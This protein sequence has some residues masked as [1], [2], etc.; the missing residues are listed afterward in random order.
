MSAKEN[1][2][3][4][5][6]ILDGN[7]QITGNVSIPRKYSTDGEGTEWPDGI[8]ALDCDCQSCFDYWQIR[9]W[10]PNL[11]HDP[12][13][14]GCN[15]CPGIPISQIFRKHPEN[16]FI[17]D[18][19]INEY[20]DRR[21]VAALQAYVDWRDRLDAKPTNP[22][23]HAADCP[24]RECE[25]FKPEPEPVYYRSFSMAE[26]LSAVDPE[27]HWHLPLLAPAGFITLLTAGPK[28]GKTQFYYG[29]LS[30]MERNGQVLG[31]RA[32]GGLRIEIWTEEPKAGIQ[33]KMN[34]VNM[35]DIPADWRIMG[36]GDVEARDWGRQIDAAIAH[37]Q[38][39]NP[40]DVLFVDTLGDWVLNE[41]WNDYAGT[42]K[43]LSPLRRVLATFPHMAIIAVHH[44]RKAKGDAVDSASGSNAL[45]GKVDNIV[46]MDATDACDD[47]TRRLRFKGRITPPDMDGVDLYVRFDPIAGTYSTER[48]G[49]R[50]EDMVMDVLPDAPD[51]L[52]AAQINDAI[53][54]DEDGV[55]P[56]LGTVRNILTRLHKAGE[57]MR[58]GVPRS[59]SYS[60]V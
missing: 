46:N 17:G 49:K 30:D 5:G 10:L 22:N 16:V 28:V 45:T 36:I 8:H 38:G 53:P 3:G 41:D 9:G 29:L 23:G 33:A 4:D 39:T 56:T 47:Y 32:L 25:Q 60:L 2:A 54:P 26:W 6:Q 1:A 21:D 18:D 55:K 42:I 34:I 35:A 20:C 13:C 48:K 40:P 14:Q 58:H 15:D 43:V 57:I 51:S 24:C 12:D 11:P 52:S 44:N 7:A 19:A 50:F 59:Y 31:K 27:P 37:W